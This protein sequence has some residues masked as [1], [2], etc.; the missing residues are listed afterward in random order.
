ML[1]Y[2]L[3]LALSKL[4]Q[5]HTGSQKHAWH[6]YHVHGAVLLQVAAAALQHMCSTR[7]DSCRQLCTSWRQRLRRRA[8]RRCARQRPAER[9]RRTLTSSAARRVLSWTQKMPWP[10]T[11]STIYMAPDA[12]SS[13]ALMMC[14]CHQA[15][16]PTP[17]ELPIQ[18]SGAEIGRHYWVCDGVLPI[19][20]W[21]WLC[22]RRISSS[23]LRHLTGVCALKGM[24]LKRSVGVLPACLAVLTLLLESTASAAGFSASASGL[25]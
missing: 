13:E 2:H 3:S 16:H 24:D 18:L 10:G 17:F 12:N 5:T 7:G 11:A 21:P 8:W 1:S 19:S 22:C 4:G 14:H 6:D 15:T 23:R 9:V 25:D 20:N